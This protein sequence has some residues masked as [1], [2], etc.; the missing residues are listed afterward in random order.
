MAIDVVFW[1]KKKVLEAE[2]RPLPPFLSSGEILDLKIR[3]SA[4]LSLP[5][6]PKGMRL[7]P[8]VCV[9]ALSCVSLLARFR[10]Y[11]DRTRLKLNDKEE[12][13]GKGR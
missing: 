12:W 13:K 11:K 9:F 2:D 6:S 8:L 5:E 3:E 1:G 10:R 4:F 7:S